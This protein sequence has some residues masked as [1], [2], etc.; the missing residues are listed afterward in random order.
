MECKVLERDS[1]EFR[2]LELV[3]QALT[4]QSKKGR[5]YYVQDTYLDYGQDWRFTTI[6]Y[7]S[8]MGGV[9]ILSPRQWKE[10]VSMDYSLNDIIK[11]I[12]E[13]KYFND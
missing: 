6:C 9:Q 7:N 8:S 1:L 10:I 5:K 13:D 11:D 2:Q 12:K 4:K 3:A